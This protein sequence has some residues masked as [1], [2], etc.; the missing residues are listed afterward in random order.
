MPSS[1]RAFVAASCIVC[2]LAL[3]SC[4]VNQSLVIAPDG[5]GTFSMHAEVSVLLKDYLVSLA[6]ISGTSGPLK[7]GRVFDA[8]A[9]RKDLQSRPGIVVQKASTPA[10]N[11]LDLELGF[12]TLQDLAGTREALND[13]GAISIVDEQDRSTLRLHLDRTTWGELARLFPPLRDPLIAELGPQANGTVTDDDY[14]AMIRF[15]IGDAAPALLQKSFFTL[16]VQPTGQ[17]IAQSG[18]TV[19]DGI[20]T[21]RIPV[22]RILVLDR[23]LNYS[24]TWAR[25]S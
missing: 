3:S 21:F 7:D 13:A 15:S 24:V 5:S 12:D 17:I 25:S 11:V 9:I 4:T 19:N 6:G 23:P 14:L 16:T 18:G 10:A 8:A 2:A 22:L 1:L 20:V